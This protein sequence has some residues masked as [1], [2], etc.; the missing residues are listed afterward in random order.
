MDI[1]KRYMK[2]LAKITNMDEMKILP[3]HLSF[4]L[5]LSLIPAVTLVG[6]ICNLLGVSNADVIEFFD[7]TAPVGVVQVIKPF[8][9]SSGADMALIYLI[10]GFILMSNGAYAIILASNTLYKIEDTSQLKGRIKAI[11]LTILLM[12][13]FVFILFVLAFGNKIVG[14]ILDLEVL[15]NVSNSIYHLF[16]YLKWPVAFFVIY[17]IIKMIYTLAPDKNVKSKTVTK[18]SIFTT[19]GW[20]IITAIY[21]FYANNIARYDMFYGNLSNIIILMMWI[22]VIAYIF[23]IGIAINVNNHNI[24]EENVI[25]NEK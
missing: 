19:I 16:V 14:F 2:K 24:M 7:E 17:V 4:Y 5:V 6:M 11:F 21:S 1:I 13:L 23:V 3:G 15:G 8:F 25:N 22:Y 12:F 10:I 20:L 9:T 18:G